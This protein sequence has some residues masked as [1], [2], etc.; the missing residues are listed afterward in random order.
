MKKR[1]FFALALFSGSMT[2]AQQK[3][4]KPPPPPAPPPAMDVQQVP[5]PIPTEPPPPPDVKLDLPK[6]YAA[7]LKQN[8]NV[9]GIE[10]S[11]NNKVHIRLRS[12]KEE[13]YDLNKEEEARRLKNKYGELP[14]P[15]PPPP[16][17]KVPV[18]NEQL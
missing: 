15:P 13:V 6:D 9:K 18:I 16:I 17:P 8:P 1:I 14:A 3:Q 4:L 7:F 5:P 11:N 10:W 12:G 2:F